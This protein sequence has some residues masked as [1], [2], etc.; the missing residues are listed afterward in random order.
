MKQ[1]QEIKQSWIGLGNFD[2]YFCEVFD[3][4]VRIGFETLPSP[5]LRFFL[6][7]LITMFFVLDIKYRFKISELHQY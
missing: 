1:F 4:I 7:F 2:I 3:H 6:Y 5:F